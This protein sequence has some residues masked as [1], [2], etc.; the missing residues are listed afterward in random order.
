MIIRLPAVF[1]EGLKKNI[2]F[3]LINKHNLTIIN[4]YDHFQ[5]FDLNL[6]FKEIHKCETEYGLNRII[7]LYSPPISNNQILKFFPKIKLFKLNRK[8]VLYNYKPKIGFYRNK[9]FILKRIKQFIDKYE[10]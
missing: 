3:D 5:W 8:K 2:L 7:E 6:L 4:K 1:G 10:L 9:K